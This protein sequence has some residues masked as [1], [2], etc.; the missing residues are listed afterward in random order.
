[1]SVLPDLYQSEGPNLFDPRNPFTGEAYVPTE[2]PRGE[3]GFYVVSDGTAKPLRVFMRTPS[4]GNLQALPALFEG[5][6]VADS[7]AALGS[8]DFVLGDVDR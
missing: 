1:M 5:H 2:S 7:V 6:L 8:M 4:F 3:I